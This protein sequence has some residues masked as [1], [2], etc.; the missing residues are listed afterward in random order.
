MRVEATFGSGSEDNYLLLDGRT[1][2][3]VFVLELA[4]PDMQ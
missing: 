4:D 2:F 3:V 1:M